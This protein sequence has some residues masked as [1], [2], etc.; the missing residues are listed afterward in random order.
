MAASRGQ[1]QLTK[2]RSAAVACRWLAARV[3]RSPLAR[4]Q[5]C[6]DGGSL[7]VGRAVRPVVP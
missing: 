3:S 6:C 7:F 2:C 4:Q 1:L 5:A